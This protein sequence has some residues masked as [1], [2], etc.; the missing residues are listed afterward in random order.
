MNW[1]P[2]LTL[3]VALCCVFAISTA[4]TSLESSVTTDPDEVIDLDTSEIPIGTDS[5][6]SL[7]SQV[8]SEG[9]P[10]TSQSSSTASSDGAEATQQSKV[11]GDGTEQTSADGGD[12]DATASGGT[13]G[14]DSEQAAGGGTQT[15]KQGLGADEETRQGPGTNESLLDRLLSLLAA[16]LDLLRSLAP[17]LVGLA[18]V[19]LGVRHRDRLVAMLRDRLERWGLLD[20][21]SD[22]AA[23]EP[24]TEAAPTNQ[25]SAAWYEFVETLGLGDVRSCA[26]RECAEVARAE[27]VDEETIDALTEPFEEVRYGEAPVTEDRRQRAR[28][29]LERFRARHDGDRRGTQYRGVGHGGGDR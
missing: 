10:D 18:L 2:L 29:G 15:Q 7:K 27:G 21:A 9:T 16:L 25:V 19:A 17:M 13:S 3:A 24:P 6:V 26:P 20:P 14:S 11:T 28:R 23:G 4:A 22:D 12:G 1:E 8:Q 5:V